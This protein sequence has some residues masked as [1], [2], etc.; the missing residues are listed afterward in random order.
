MTAPDEPID[1]EDLC[2]GQPQPLDFAYDLARDEHEAADAYQQALLK[3]IESPPPDLRSARA[4]LRTVARNSLIQSMRADGRRRERERRVARVEESRPAD[5][6]ELADI[7]RCVKATVTELAEPYRTTLLLRYW[8]ELGPDA[9]ARRTN[10]PASTVRTRLARGLAQVRARLD[11]EYEG[12]R[13]VWVLSIAVPGVKG[14]LVD[15]SLTGEASASALR[16][17]ARGTEDTPHHGTQPSAR[18][19]RATSG[20]VRA[21]VVAVLIACAL[22][23]WRFSAGAES[24]ATETVSSAGAA[25]GVSA[26]T[27]RTRVRVAS[28]EQELASESEAAEAPVDPMA[29]PP[30]PPLRLVVRRVERASSGESRVMPAADVPVE[31]HRSD[32]Q[33]IL[34][35][36]A[37]GRVEPLKTTRTDD[38]GEAQFE[39]LV[40]GRYWVRIDVPGYALDVE[41]VVL[42]PQGARSANYVPSERK[43]V[44][45]LLRPTDDVDLIVRD[46]E[47]GRPIPGAH[48]TALVGGQ[49]QIDSRSWAMIG[50]EPYI[51]DEG[52]TDSDGALSLRRLA[53]TTISSHTFFTMAEGYAQSQQGVYHTHFQ[54]GDTVVISLQRGATLNGTVHDRAGRPEPGLAVVAIPDRRGLGENSDHTFWNIVSELSTPSS[55]HA[56][57]DSMEEW[58]GQV[59]FCRTRPDGTFEFDALTPGTPYVVVVCSAAHFSSVQDAPLHLE[60]G[61]ARTLDIEVTDGRT[62]RLD[63]AGPEGTLEPA[64]WVWCSLDG[65]GWFEAAEF[66]GVPGAFRAMIP[67]GGE[68]ESCRY[69]CNRRSS[70]GRSSRYRPRPSSAA[71]LGSASRPDAPSRAGSSTT[72][73]SR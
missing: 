65:Q 33:G 59:Q 36:R 21:T 69:P 24:V 67:E 9:I 48:V 56:P 73:D 37:T 70:R 44:E 46:V 45:L 60:A 61:E 57:L 1:L 5:A 16:R 20:V 62:F 18:A 39:G 43:P 15:A 58:V 64:P 13:A 30:G 27:P 8:A 29:E 6:L 17:T 12:E 71:T 31:V 38:A 52:V 50:L 51:A 14:A 35:V 68:T 28:V 72:P 55:L 2:R 53:A 41:Q 54:R 32:A 19:K 11:R 3:M 23:V 34:W 66:V 7:R 63:V 4:W 26:D 40:C 22:G 47:S 42:D 10:V 49:A 25:G